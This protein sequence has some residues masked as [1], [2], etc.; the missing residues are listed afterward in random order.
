VGEHMERAFW[1]DL[2]WSNPQIRGLGLGELQSI[3]GQLYGLPVL[4]ISEGKQP[5]SVHVVDLAEFDYLQ[6]NPSPENDGDLLFHVKQLTQDEAV[7]EIERR[8]ELL[9]SLYRSTYDQEGAL[10]REDGIVRLQLQ[11]GLR[12]AEAGRVQRVDGDLS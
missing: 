5:P 11:V 3:E 9:Q 12:V 2:T 6:E 4:H 7:Q 1:D 10:D 8:S